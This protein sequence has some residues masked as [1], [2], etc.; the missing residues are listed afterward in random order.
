M[1]VCVCVLCVCVCVCVRVCG[2]CGGGEGGGG[3]WKDGERTSTRKQ[4]HSEKE[5]EGD[6]QA[7]EHWRADFA[8]IFAAVSVGRIGPG[9]GSVACKR[10]GDRERCVCV[11]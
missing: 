11:S 3:K 6:L 9:E 4:R 10:L 8:P 1:C 7:L 5:R 2:V